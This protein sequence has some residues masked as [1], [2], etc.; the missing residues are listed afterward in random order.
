MFEWFVY[1]HAAHS[2]CGSWA[3]RS[4]MVATC[5]IWISRTE[6]LPSGLGVGALGVGAF[7][8][9]AIL[10]TST[11]P[12]NSTDSIST[13]KPFKTKE[14]DLLATRGHSSEI[15]VFLLDLNYTPAQN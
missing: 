13:T 5:P 3:F 11:L 14:L 10:L 4:G 8:A 2:M 12:L 1:T 6:R 7:Y 9:W 15:P